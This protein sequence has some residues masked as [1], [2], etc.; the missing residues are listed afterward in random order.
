M[1]QLS[2]VRYDLNPSDFMRLDLESTERL[3][4]LGLRWQARNED[5]QVDRMFDEISDDTFSND[6]KGLNR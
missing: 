6:W 4:D 1:K 3:L 5:E 2:P